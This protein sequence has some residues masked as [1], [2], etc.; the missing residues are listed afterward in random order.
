MLRIA[1]NLLATR[2]S[3]YAMT[4]VAVGLVV[5]MYVLIT[6]S[7]D[8]MIL[9]FIGHVDQTRADLWVL[10]PSDQPMGTFMERSIADDVLAV[11]GVS[12]VERVLEVPAYMEYGDTNSRIVLCGYYIGGFNEPNPIVKGSSSAWPL[13]PGIVIDRSLLLSNPGLA[14][15]EFVEIAG[16]RFEVIGIT[17]G[18]QLFAAYPVVFIPIDL[19]SFAGD[20]KDKA[21]YFLVRTGQG[22]NL[23]RVASNIEAAADGVTV[24]TKTQYE[25][26]L[27]A[28]F[29]YAQLILSALQ[30][31][32]AAIGTLIVGVTVYTSVLERA[33]ELGIIKAIGGTNGYLT[34]LVLLD[35]LILAVP[36]YLVGAVLAALAVRALPVVLPIRAEYDPA[37]FAAAGAL[38][39]GVAVL[40]S[41]AG[42]RSAVRVDPLA[43]IRGC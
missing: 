20:L 4:I 37:V 5:F 9:T 18:H 17:Q 33:R 39:L 36:G 8:G 32:T 7:L 23:E 41:M 35:G 42:V 29:G 6:S 11:E 40:G 10:S 34:R 1:L 15:G 25:E 26:N 31:A 22:A 13:A 3:R 16:E 21:N 2:R 19:L 38:A 14:V 24:Y 28:D 30:I 27:L 12:D 43:A